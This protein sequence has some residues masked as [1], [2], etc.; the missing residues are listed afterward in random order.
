MGQALLMSR[1][2]AHITFDYTTESQYHNSGQHCEFSRCESMKA[3][4]FRGTPSG[5]GALYHRTCYC[6]WNGQGSLIRNAD[7]CS[8]HASMSEYQE[9]FHNDLIRPSFARAVCSV[10][11]S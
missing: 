5:T 11:S 10:S 1:T 8:N 4:F 6:A 9:E 3:D 2:I 7:P